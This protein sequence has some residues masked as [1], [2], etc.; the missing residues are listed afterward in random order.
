MCMLIRNSQFIQSLWER[1]I[2]WVPT[3]KASRAPPPTH[4]HNIP[5]PF[6]G[7]SAFLHCIPFSASYQL[8]G[9]LTFH[10]TLF[11]LLHR[12]QWVT[13]LANN[14]A[15]SYISQF[16]F[17]GDHVPG[18]SIEGEHPGRTRSSSTEMKKSSQQLRDQ[19]H[20]HSFSLRRWVRDHRII[21]K[22]W[23]G[24]QPQQMVGIKRTCEMRMKI[25]G[26]MN[27]CVNNVIH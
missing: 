15:F 2:S 9:F 6:P 7:S 14:K 16:L 19:M 8:A 25:R 21:P 18:L 24:C 13:I 1:M 26:E 10:F 11:L 20:L 27:L 5:I 3:G 22:G 17:L 4:T 12:A 23:E